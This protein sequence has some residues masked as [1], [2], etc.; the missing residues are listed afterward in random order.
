MYYELLKLEN[1]MNMSKYSL[2]DLALYFE[3]YDSYVCKIVTE[4]REIKFKIEVNSL[5]HLIGL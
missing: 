1:V 4:K 2:K 3:R 5:P